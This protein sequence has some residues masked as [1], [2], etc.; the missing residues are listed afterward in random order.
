MQDC[1]NS[2][3]YALELLQSCTMPSICDDHAHKSGLHKF[4]LNH[5]TNLISLNGKA[6]I[7]PYGMFSVSVQLIVGCF[8]TGD[9]FEYE[10]P[11][12]IRKFSLRSMNQQISQK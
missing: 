4:Y 1:S 11:T 5:T 2:I 6:P 9:C 8:A 10:G 12:A 3:A 7:Y